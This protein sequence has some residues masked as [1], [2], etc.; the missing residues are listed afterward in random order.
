MDKVYRSEAA[1]IVIQR[2][3]QYV[4]RKIVTINQV[5]ELLGVSRPTWYTWKSGLTAPPS[6]KL[7]ILKSILAILVENEGQL[8]KVKASGFEIQDGQVRLKNAS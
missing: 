3:Q 5:I 4:D 6:D 7:T 1:Q 8:T 2:L